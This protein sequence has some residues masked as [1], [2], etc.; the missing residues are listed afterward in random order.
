MGILGVWMWSSSIRLRGAEEV[1]SHCADAGVT[2]IYF[3]VKGLLGTAAY[4]SSLVPNDGERDLLAEAL[5]AAHKRNIRLHAWYTTVCD[6]QYVA[7]HP[8]SGRFHCRTGPDNQ[9][10]ALTDTG[11]PLYMESVV[12]EI[13]RNYPIDG[14]HLDYIR[15]NHITSGWSEKDLQCYAAEGADP[16]ELRHMLDR[17]YYREE[18]KDETLLFDAYRAGEKNA[19]AFANVRRKQVVQFASRLRDAAKAERKNLIMTA[20]LMPEG[21]YDDTAFADLHY[22]QKY[23]DAAGLYDYVLPMAYTKTYEKDGV[24][25]QKLADNCFRAGLKTVMGLQAFSPSTGST[26]RDDIAALRDAST[27]GICLFR[28]GSCVMAYRNGRSLKVY[29]A[30]EGTVT[31]IAAVCGENTAERQTELKPDAEICWELPFTPDC[32]RAFCGEKEICVFTADP[33]IK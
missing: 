9:M 5:D 25:L 31:G 27:E 20:A 2:D 16:E 8:E 1:I 26:L 21:A 23:A 10:V 18:G 6:R 33:E 3:L 17:M 19:V 15:Y 4:Q 32:V 28:E 14:I 12:Q 24:W 30:T 22:G 29:N 13:C 7:S 11:Y